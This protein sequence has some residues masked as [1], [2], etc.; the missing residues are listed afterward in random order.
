MNSLTN[1]HTQKHLDIRALRTFLRNSR[2]VLK[3]H[4]A[5][6]FALEGEHTPHGQCEE[7]YPSSGCGLVRVT[8]TSTQIEMRGVP[9]Q[10]SPSLSFLFSP[11]LP[12]A[13]AVLTCL[14]IP[15]PSSSLT[16]TEIEPH[17][18][19]PPCLAAFSQTHPGDP[20]F[21]LPRPAACSVWSPA[22]GYLWAC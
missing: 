22:C 10:R 2:I 15:Q 17:G 16:F 4:F 13:R 5:V 9:G 11:S 7:V 3:C 18:M 12:K 14:T 1:N 21:L 19:C 8:C 6:S 20:A